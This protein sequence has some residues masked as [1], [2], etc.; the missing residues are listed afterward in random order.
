MAPTYLNTADNF[1]AVD[2][3]ICCSLGLECL[4]SL[5]VCITTNMNQESVLIALH[6]GIFSPRGVPYSSQAHSMSLQI[7]AVVLISLCNSCL[8][9]LSYHY[10]GFEFLEDKNCVLFNLHNS[11]LNTA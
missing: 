7:S 6:D 10:I 3:C 8:L 9:V 4:F 1:T 11:S 2:L 5:S